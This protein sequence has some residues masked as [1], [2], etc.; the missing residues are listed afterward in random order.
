M[1]AFRPKALKGVLEALSFVFLALETSIGESRQNLE[2][3]SLVSDIVYMIIAACR[4]CTVHSADV[5]FI[6]IKFNTLIQF[7]F[8]L[9]VKL[10]REGRGEDWAIFILK[11]IDFHVAHLCLC[12]MIIMQIVRLMEISCRLRSWNPRL[13]RTE[14]RQ[15][16]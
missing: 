3:D 14:D 2:M 12:Y 6:Q 5:D 7:F 15:R 9:Q 1:G 11:L 4:V 16:M 10:Y 8:R 13:D